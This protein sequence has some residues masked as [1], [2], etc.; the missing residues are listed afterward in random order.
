MKILCCKCR[1]KYTLGENIYDVSERF[2]DR[3]INPTKI[4]KCPFCNFE[5]AIQFIPL[6]KNNIDR[7]KA[8]QVNLIVYY[9]DLCATRIADEDRTWQAGVDGTVTD[10]PRSHNFIYA[11]VIGTS[12]GPI[13]RAYK[14]QWRNYTADPT[15]VFTDVGVGDIVPGTDTVLVDDGTL[16]S[17][18]ASGGICI[19]TLWQDGLENEGDTILPDVG[20]YS[21]AD[22][23]Y[24]EFQWALSGLNA[25][26]NDLYEFQ[27]YDVTEAAAIGIGSAKISFI[28][29]RLS[30]IVSNTITFI[31]SKLL[32]NI[33]RVEDRFWRDE[34]HTV[35]TLTKNQL[36]TVY[37]STAGLISKSY[38][39]PALP[40]GVP[41]TDWSIKIWVR[42]VISR[43][44]EDGTTLSLF[45]LTAPGE[46]YLFKFLADTGVNY[47]SGWFEIP[48][49]ALAPTDAVL[50]QVEVRLLFT[51]DGNFYDTGWDLFGE[52]ITEQ[53][54][55]KSL[56]ETA[57]HVAMPM[58]ATS[59]IIFTGEGAEQLVCDVDFY[60]DNDYAP[61]NSKIG[62]FQWSPLPPPI[63]KLIQ[64]TNGLVS[65]LT[66]G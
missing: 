51:Y 46:I 36:S 7:P 19:Q 21:L 9:V 30:N 48:G 33:I 24:T 41:I 42:L 49:K 34:T 38:L 65:I 2:E 18:D 22:E 5:H 64:Y 1:K 32:K 39:A 6:G 4:L 28:T 47:L 8:K 63:V 16:A 50:V 25:V 12:K 40:P 17:A 55:A 61:L 10:Y 3:V 62:N 37:D 58:N 53:L 45:T 35:N 15:G 11:T 20:V 52:F 43:V 66:K 27:L 59:G 14:L 57:W 60:I 31:S 54:G 23:Y 29:P 13:D 26:E 56:V 44:K